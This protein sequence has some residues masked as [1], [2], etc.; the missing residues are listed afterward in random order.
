MVFTFGS[1]IAF[2][3]SEEY[4]KHAASKYSDRVDYRRSRSGV[5]Q[6]VHSDGRRNQDDFERGRRGRRID[7]GLTGN[8]TLGAD[9]QLSAR[10]MT[11]AHPTL[12]R[13][14]TGDGQIHALLAGE[15]QP[16]RTNDPRKGLR[17]PA[18]LSSERKAYD[19]KGKK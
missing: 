15:S 7:L 14:V 4:Y 9:Q 10:S 11:S 8:W 5:D 6:Q 16:K 2:P 17:A 3:D 12:L 19:R 1:S 18:C 13:Q